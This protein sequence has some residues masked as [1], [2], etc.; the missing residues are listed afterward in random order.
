VRSARAKADSVI[1]LMHWGNEYV[2]LPTPSQREIGAALAAAGADLIVG[3][4]PHVIQGTEISGSSVIAYSMGNFVFDQDTPE[5]TQGLALRA[6]FD[7][8]GLRGVQGLPVA[9]SAQPRLLTT[10]DAEDLLPHIQPP[11]MRIGFVCQPDGCIPADVPQDARQGIF[12]GGQ[13]DLTGDGVPEIVRR[14]GERLLIYEGGTLVYETPP[15]WR[16]VDAALGDPNDD[17]RYELMLAI[18]Q[19][20]ANG[21]EWSQ[22]YIVGYR[23][24]EY[25]L[26]WGGRAVFDPIEEIEV[27]DIDGD[28]TQ[29]LVVIEQ[30]DSGLDGISVW[31]WAGW[32]FA[33]VW[34]GPEGHY[35]D[36][37]LLAPHAG[38]S[39][40]VTVA[41][42][43]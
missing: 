30:R 12:W 13:I 40:F 21:V 33:L 3:C 41:R 8:H 5:T 27:G 29:E 16:I 19:A 11:A 17:G 32:S 43:P 4:H 38:D 39:L 7:A 18:W 15:E 31:R 25:R 28:G 14:E 35:D 9:A 2:P 1:V 10:Q 36:L 24:G 26:M 6:L 37:V 42:T 22:P 23:G 34:R 20:D